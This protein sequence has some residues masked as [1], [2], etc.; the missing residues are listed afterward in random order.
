MV[1]FVGAEFVIVVA[2]EL[3][4]ALLVGQVEFEVDSWQVIDAP[5]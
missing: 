3:A 4:E 5:L 2:V 1:A